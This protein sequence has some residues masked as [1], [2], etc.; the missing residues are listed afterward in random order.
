MAVFNGA[1]PILPGKLDDA[2]AFAQ[3]TMG[4]HRADF[5]DAQKRAGVTR[6]T[7][8]IETAPDGGSFVLV[9]FEASDP[10][11]AFTQLM[12]DSDHSVWFRARV[13]EVT[14]V[15]LSEP[16]SGDGPEVVVDWTP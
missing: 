10:E 8:T 5:D 16:P 3:E 14:G 4:S 12:D 7:W 15:D 11:V 1:F 2:R 6:E 9:W 13:K